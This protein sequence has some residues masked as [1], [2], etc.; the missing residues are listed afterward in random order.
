MTVKL[1]NM[2]QVEPVYKTFKEAIASLDRPVASNFGVVRLWKWVWLIV[3]GCKFE[4]IAGGK[5][6]NH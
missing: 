4:L 5:W 1:W 3:C 6:L 2:N